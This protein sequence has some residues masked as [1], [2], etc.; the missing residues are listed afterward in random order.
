MFD[1]A[2]ILALC[3]DSFAIRAE[4]AIAAVFVCEALDIFIV[5]AIVFV[6]KYLLVVVPE[7]VSI[8]ILYDL[9]GFFSHLGFV[10]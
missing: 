6:L 5:A 1:T 3:S 8:V 2:F 4:D 9:P 7:K 10:F